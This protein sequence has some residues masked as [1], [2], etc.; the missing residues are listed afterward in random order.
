MKLST[1]FEKSV[2]VRRR[3]SAPARKRLRKAHNATT[4]G[5]LLQLLQVGDAE[6]GVDLYLQKVLGLST[7]DVRALRSELLGALS[8]DDAAAVQAPCREFAGGVPATVPKARIERLRLPSQRRKLAKRCSLARACTP[9]RDQGRR[10]TCVAQAA[11]AMNEH[12]HRSLRVLLSPQYLYGHCKRR[13]GVRGPGTHLHVA[14]GVL[15]DKGQCKEESLVYDGRVK[16]GN[17]GHE[18]IPD[19]LDAEALR[20]RMPCGRRVQV[21]DVEDLCR[22]LAGFDS[23]GGRI[24]GRPVLFATKLYREFMGGETARTGKVLEPLPGSRVVGH[25]AMLLVGYELDPSLPGEGRFIV[26]NSWGEGWAHQNPD[27]G[28]HCHISFQYVKRHAHSFAYAL[29]TQAEADRMAGR[30]TAAAPRKPTA[31]KGLGAVAALAGALALAVHAPSALRP[32]PVVVREGCYAYWSEDQVVE[33]AV[34]PSETLWAWSEW[35]GVDREALADWNDLDPEDRLRT[36]ERLVVRLDRSPTFH[37]VQRG[38]TL[39][40]IQ[41]RYGIDNPWQVKALNCMSGGTVYVGETL[42]LL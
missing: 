2:A 14:L 31:L 33:K 3:V 7:E 26:R 10:G 27:G 21:R 15:G 18:P 11:T 6:P 32:E 40:G 30:K 20:F 37:E 34:M 41:D 9:V 22:I 1:P 29:F 36:G 28:G 8:R 39:S 13:D 5:D 24:E 38:D 4:V 12:L 17:E 19:R 35:Y 25:H 42:M 23:P 16:P